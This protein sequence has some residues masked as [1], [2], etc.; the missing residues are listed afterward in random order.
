MPALVRAAGPDASRR[1]LE[2][3][4]AQIRNPNTRRP[5]AALLA[6]SLSGDINQVEPSRRSGECARAGSLSKLSVIHDGFTIDRADTTPL[7]TEPLAIP[8]PNVFARKF[9]HIMDRHRSACAH[10]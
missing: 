9:L 8:F 7:D 2:N 4:A 10:G 6:I 1:S 5:T 3:F